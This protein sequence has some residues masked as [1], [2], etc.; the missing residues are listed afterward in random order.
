MPTFPR[1]LP[2]FKISIAI[3]LGI[4]IQ[5]LLKVDAFILHFRLTLSTLS[6]IGLHQ[7]YA[8]L[9]RGLFL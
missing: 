4:Y 7:L 1:E 8:E 6:F 2:L 5:E 3:A 9:S